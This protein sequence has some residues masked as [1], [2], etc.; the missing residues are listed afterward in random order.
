MNTI[1]IEEFIKDSKKYFHFVCSNEDRTSFY[2]VVH[3]YNKLEKV[4]AMHDENHDC[5]L[6]ASSLEKE[7]RGA[8]SEVGG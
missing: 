4:K 6:R 5:G 8:N 3:E 7:Q 1:N 2:S